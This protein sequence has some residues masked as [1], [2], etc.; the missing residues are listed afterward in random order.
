MIKTFT[1]N[2]QNFLIITGENGYII[3][4][5]DFC[6]EICVN[7]ERQVFTLPDGST[8]N[9]RLDEM[10]NQNNDIVDIS[11]F[12]HYWGIK[13]RVHENYNLLLKSML[14]IKADDTEFCLMPAWGK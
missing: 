5:N 11:K 3:S 12:G 8:I 9:F 6:H 4:E 1:F 13:S 14:E 10:L 2:T 7:D